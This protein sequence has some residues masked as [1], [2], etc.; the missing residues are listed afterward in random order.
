M[1]WTS[2]MTAADN[3]IFTSAQW[4]TH[5]RDNMNQSLVALATAANQSF[6][7]TGTNV[8]A[9][10]TIASDVDTGLSTTASATYA[11]LADAL[12]TAVTLTTGTQALV[13]IQAELSH[14]VTANVD[15]SASYAVTGATSSVAADSKRI[16]LDGVAANSGN[17]MG[18]FFWDTGLTAG[19]NTFTMQYKT[20]AGASLQAAKREIIVWG[21]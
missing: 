12:A 4:N 5:V 6:V 21:F 13:F 11:L 14:S 3:T 2:P 19:S 9:A 17:R 15:V 16:L 7:T 20:S 18:A 1:A 8:L 10:R